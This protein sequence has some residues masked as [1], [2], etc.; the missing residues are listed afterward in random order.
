MSQ[1]KPQMD[2]RKLFQSL[3]NITQPNL[4]TPINQNFNK[5]NNLNWKYSVINDTFVCKG[6]LAHTIYNHF[7]TF[8]NYIKFIFTSADDFTTISYRSIKYLQQSNCLV[9]SLIEYGGFL[10]QR[11]G[12]VLHKKSFKNEINVNRWITISRTFK[13]E[14]FC[15]IYIHTGWI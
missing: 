2:E 7:S 3:I 4:F 11:S 12:T 14:Y 8:V 13:L 5:K 10:C 15:F 6:S 9:Q 1:K